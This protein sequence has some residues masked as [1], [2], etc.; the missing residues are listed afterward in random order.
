MSLEPMPFLSGPVASNAGPHEHRDPPSDIVSVI[1]LSKVQQA[2]WLDY[3][4]RP[5]VSHYHLRLEI[6]VSYLNPSLEKILQVIQTLGNSHQMLRTTFHLDGDN[7]VNRPFMAVHS[8]DT[9]VQRFEIINDEARLSSSLLRGFNLSAEFPVRWVIHH[10]VMF[11]AGNLQT[12]CKLFAIGH[13]IA[14]D[15]FSLSILSKEILQLLDVQTQQPAA[16]QSG[17]SYGEYVQRQDAYLRSVSGRA[18]KEFWLSQVMHTSPFSWRVA[19][20]VKTTADYRRMHTWA[21]FP[22]EQLQKWSELYKTSWFRV[23]STVVSLV[24]DGNA[25]P[26]PHHDRALFV[27]FGARPKEFQNCV[28]H[29]A[30]TMPVKVPLARLLQNNA[31]FLEAVKAFGKNLSIAKKHEMYPFLSL[32]EEARKKMDERQLNFKVAVTFSPKLASKSCSIYPV[33]GVW[34]LFFC[35]LEHDDGVSLGVIANPD[36]FG[37]EAMAKL[38]AEFITTAKL[39]QQDNSFR[40]RDLPSFRDRGVA[41]ITNGPAVE[42]VET[43]SSSRVHLWIKQRAAGQPNTIALSSAE[44]NETMT[45][46]ELAER[47]SQVAHYL[48]AN[49]VSSGEGVLLHIARG[50]KTVVW[51]LGILEAGAYYVVLDR[52][53]PD[54]RKAAIAATSK[55]RFLVTDDFKIQQVLFDLAITVVSLDVVDRELQT[56]PVT[57]LDSTTKDNDL[58]YIVFTSGSTGQPK[59]VMVEQ[60]NLSHYVSATSSVVKIGPGSRVLQFATFAFDASVLEWAVTL[61]YGATLCFVDHPELLVGD[62]LATVID[63][64]EVNFFHTTPSVLATIPTDRYLASLRM[65]SVGGEPSSTGLLGKWRQRSQL[66]HA[67]GPTETTVIVTVEVIGEDQRSDAPLPSPSKIGKPFPNS[68]ILICADDNNDELPTGEH[69]EI[70]IAGPQVSRG[71]IGQTELTQKHFHTIQLDGH[72]TRMYR[73]GDR[74]FLDADGKLCIGGRMKNREIK[75]RGYRMDLYEIE[76]SILD[77]SPEVQVASVQV[78]ADS[79]VAFVVPETAPCDVIRGRL[80]LEVPSYSLPARFFAVRSLPLNSNGKIDHAQVSEQL[81]SLLASSPKTSPA[82]KKISS[83]NSKSIESG[84]TSSRRKSVSKVLRDLWTQTLRLT[85]PPSSDISFFEAGGHSITLIELHKRIISR[86]PGC[87]ISLLDI[88]QAPTI[89]KQ[90]ACLAG[91]MEVSEQ[92]PPFSESNYGSSSGSDSDSEAPTA[93]TSLSNSLDL[94]DNK[95]AIVGL[96]GYFPGAVDV[97]SFWQMIINGK[98]AVKSHDEVVAP[99]DMAEDEIFVPRYGSMPDLPPVTAGAWNMTPEEA[100]LTDPQKLLFLSIASEALADARIPITKGVPNPTGVFIG[101]AHNTHKDAPNTP[102]PADSFQ[103]RHRTLLDPPISTFTAYKLNLTGPNA[104]LNTACSSALVALQHALSALR[105]GE[106]PAAL[107]GGVTVAF[108]QLGG[109]VTAPGQVFSPTGHCRP[110]DAA[111][112]GSV[113]ADAVAA[114]V[115]KTLSAARR[116]NDAVYAVIEGCATGSDGS[117]DKVGFTVPSSTGQARTVAKAIRSAGVAPEAFRYVELHGSGTSMG[118]ALEVSGLEQAL[119]QVQQ[120][121]EVNG[122]VVHVGSNKGAFGNTEAASGMLSLIK[123]ALA[124]S[125]GF[126]PPMP[127]LNALNPMCNFEGRLRPL[128][129]QLKLAQDDRVG[130]TSLGYGGTNAHTV[131]CAAEAHGVQKRLRS[132]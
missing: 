13:H 32:I 90:A 19:P 123:M 47:S 48:V 109:Y 98:T 105:A 76:K 80:A 122:C 68:R 72:D 70:C 50:F 89:E 108:P 3:L 96:A 29:M 117:V 57:T 119:D 115:V 112:D 91:K 128:V 84:A 24:T 33:E 67:F 75:L 20:P 21:F 25:E 30:N 55:A 121:G 54:K 64:N 52:K 66:L 93:A 126:I 58:A 59:G 83:T 22:N 18:A 15:G 94:D 31:T 61:S 38:Q 65:L 130:V 12:K 56:Q 71:Y 4:V 79:L 100:G 43:I 17:L 110:L 42:D 26:A 11:E 125:N 45:Y 101:S 116:D 9:S 97:D 63:K 129:G 81:E 39:S 35:F 37:D 92:R 127:K 16:E 6:D 44:R 95:F 88:F 28:S 41:S 106:C 34:D 103:A 27:A 51:L 86:F 131:L 46:R 49:G 14:V 23:A 132:A 111:A 114:V 5:H 85:S 60:S 36:V 8:Q 78:H 107:V 10:S 99:S 1:P 102:L 62:Y 113:P 82:Q 73:T 74:G 69:G 87:E 118:D 104:T 53:L 77:N 124:I 2:L 120:P 40:L 7:Q